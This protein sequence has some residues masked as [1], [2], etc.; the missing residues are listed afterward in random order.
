MIN[1]F[2]RVENV[3]TKVHFGC[4]AI[5]TLIRELLESGC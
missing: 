4:E 2:I 3:K 1:I 5:T